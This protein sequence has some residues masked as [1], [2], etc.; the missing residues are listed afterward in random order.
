MNLLKPLVL[1][2]VMLV[3]SC[4]MRPSFQ[5]RNNYS[6]DYE[7][8]PQRN[9]GYQLFYDQLSPYG[10]WTKYQNYGY[11]WIPD[12]G[13]NF[14]PY[15]TA[16]RWVMTEYGWTWLSDYIWGWAPFHYGRW[17]YDNYYGWF[18]VPGYEWGPSWVIWRRANGY[19]GWTP[20]RPGMNINLSIVGGSRDVERWNFI[21]ERDFTSPDIN[22]RVIDRRDNEM[23]FRNSTVINNTYIDNSRNETYVSGPPAHEVQ[24]S[25]SRRIQ[26][27]PVRDADRPG[28][29]ISDTQLQIYRPRLEESSSN[30]ERPSRVAK[31]EEI[32]PASDRGGVIQRRSQASED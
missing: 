25:T 30:Q 14:Y 2:I 4:A 3:S 10:Q 7:N 28:T 11:V 9:S 23:I 31:P 17:D 18:W 29:R 19:Y 26:S 13:R 1:L 24:R 22:R 12:A 21:R 20:M 15:L 5:G 32:R 8:Y 27:V 6:N 16:G